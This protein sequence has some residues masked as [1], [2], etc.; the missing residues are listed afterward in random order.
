MGTPPSHDDEEFDRKVDKDVKDNWAGILVDS[1]LSS[2]DE[3]RA[4]LRRVAQG[5]PECEVPW[6]EVEPLRGRIR[7]DAQDLKKTLVEHGLIPVLRDP[8][9]E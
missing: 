6:S 7:Q 1:I 8:Q 5:Q 3:L 2:A 4:E 9:K